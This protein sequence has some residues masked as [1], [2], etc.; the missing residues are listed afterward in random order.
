MQEQ[1]LLLAQLV[2]ENKNKIK[3]KIGVGISSKNVLLSNVSKMFTFPRQIAS[4]SHFRIVYGLVL[5]LR[6]PLHYLYHFTDLGA[7]VLVL[8]L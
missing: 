2:N 5:W 6:S 4:N 7:I 1:L 3:G 8:K